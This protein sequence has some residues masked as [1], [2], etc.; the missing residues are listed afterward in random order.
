MQK[1]AKDDR[2]FKFIETK[3]NS[4]M[5]ALASR[6]PKYSFL[7]E[8]PAFGGGRPENLGKFSAITGTSV[9][10]QLGDGQ[11][12]KRMSAP[13][14]WYQNPCDASIFLHAKPN[15]R[16]KKLKNLI[17]RPKFDLFSGFS[18]S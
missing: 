11:F 7:Q 5:I 3:R 6:T 12:R 18:P 4:Q 13:N 9:V 10:V 17:F 2:I 16:P 8:D 15:F 14:L 1:W